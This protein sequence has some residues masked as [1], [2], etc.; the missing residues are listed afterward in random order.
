MASVSGWTEGILFSLAFLAILTIVIINF[1]GMYNQT[2]MVG[3]NDSSNSQSLFV[4]YQDTA[5]NQVEGGEVD[6]NANQ[7]ITL[8]SSYGLIKDLISI[9]WRFL[10]GGWIEQVVDMLNLGESGNALA[11]TLRV[12]YF[13]S[14]VSALLYGLFKVIV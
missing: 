1:N 5:Q 9:V 10:S 11:F 12:L 7:G 13:L 6:F 8:K 14:L 4:A 2:Y 3:L